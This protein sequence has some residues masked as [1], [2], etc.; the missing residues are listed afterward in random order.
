MIVLVV[1][2]YRLSLTSRRLLV[3]IS[4]GDTKIHSRKSQ[5]VTCDYLGPHIP[6]NTYK[7][8]MLFHQ[9]MYCQFNLQFDNNYYYYLQPTLVWNSI[10]LYFFLIQFIYKISYT[11]PLL[12][13]LSLV[14]MRQQATDSRCWWCQGI[15][16][17]EYLP[18]S[19][20]MPTF[21]NTVVFK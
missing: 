11:T 16:D 1:Y 21:A 19:G 13:H 6:Y 18:V 14:E 10:F 20:S 4:R 9:H 5:N 15:D 12:K 17:N 8:I 2:C 3:S 7:F